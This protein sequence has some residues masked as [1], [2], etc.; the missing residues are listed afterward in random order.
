MKSQRR[1]RVTSAVPIVSYFLKDIAAFVEAPYYLPYS[2]R[3]HCAGGRRR[4]IAGLKPCA[5]EVWSD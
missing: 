2:L 1:Y 4:F 5:T 3:R